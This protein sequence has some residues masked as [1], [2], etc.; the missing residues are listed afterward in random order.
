ME[1]NSG[2]KGLSYSCDGRMCTANSLPLISWRVT[3]AD[4]LTNTPHAFSCQQPSGRSQPTW[5]HAAESS[6][7]SEHVL[8]QSRNSPH[9]TEPLGSLP[10]SQQPATCSYPKLALYQGISAN[11]SI[12]EMFSNMVNFNSKGVV[13][14]SPHPQA[15]G[16]P[17]DGRPRL[18]IRHIHSYPLYLEARGSAVGWGTALQVGRSRVRFPMVS[19]EFFHWHNPSGRTMALGLTQPLTEMSTRNI[20]WGGKGGRC[21]RLTNLT[22]F[23]CRLSWNL[24]ASNSWNPQGLSRPVMGLLYLLTSISGHCSCIRNL[25]TLHAMA[26][27]THLSR[28]PGPIKTNSMALTRKMDLLSRRYIY[29]YIFIYIYISRRLL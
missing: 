22:T 24:G 8:S 23:M 10:Y 18:F 6:L 14:T 17:L 2:F 4:K 29:I 26:T 3:P 25:R 1:F 16:P 27:L 13:T 15:G 21:V 7:T 28:I 11:P 19:L 5:F 12:C 9:S 20:S